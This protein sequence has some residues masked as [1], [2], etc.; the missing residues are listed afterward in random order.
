MPAM[1]E[2]REDLISDTGHMS[3]SEMPAMF[4]IHAHSFCTLLQAFCEKKMVSFSRSGSSQLSYVKIPSPFIQ[5]KI[6][7]FFW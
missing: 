7:L 3:V 6:L 5:N 2:A 1:L 4:M